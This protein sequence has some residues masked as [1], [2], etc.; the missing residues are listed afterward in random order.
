MTHQKIAALEILNE[1]PNTPTM[2]LAKLAYKRHPALWRNLEGARNVFRDLRG[3]HGKNRLMLVVKKHARPKGDPSD[4][5]FDKLPEPLKSFDEPWQSVQIEDPG[6]CLIL[7]DMHIPYHDR[8]VLAT[9]LEYGRRRKP[10]TVVLLGDVA[11]HF[12][13]SF[14]QN[15]PR[16]RDF[17]RERHMVME[18]LSYL[19]ELF[20]KAYV[21]YK[22][23]NHEDRLE[24][25]MRVKAPELIGLECLE[26][27]HLYNLP[28]LGISCIGDNRP[29]RIGKLNLIHGHEY[30]F[31]ISNP[32]NPARGLYLRGKAHAICGHFH[33]TSQ[34]SEKSLEEKVTSCWSLGCLCDIHPEYRPLNGWS[35]GFGY[36]QISDDGA[37]QVDNLR[38][39]DGKAY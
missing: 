34:H 23:G 1:F 22:L 3:A 2:T 18:F 9:A 35:H 8:K 30:K 31:A 33:Q 38:I 19:R 11:D 28:K 27:P 25:Y 12:A 15:D 39:I 7:S 6:D 29:I 16:E 13:C 20:P 4:S 5:V 32:V 37:F 14:W 24:R 36:V 26:F 21:V 17:A 10:D